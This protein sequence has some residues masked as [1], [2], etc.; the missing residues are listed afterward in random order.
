MAWVSGSHVDSVGLSRRQGIYI[1]PTL[2]IRGYVHGTDQ[3]RI[4]TRCRLQTRSWALEG[5]TDEVRLNLKGE[6]R[7]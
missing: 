7:T 4:G 1:Y 5:W 2:N 3:T 6:G